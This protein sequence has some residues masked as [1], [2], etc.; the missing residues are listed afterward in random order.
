MIKFNKNPCLILDQRLIDVFAQKRFDE[1][2]DLNRI[3]Y[4]N[5]ESK[6]LD[7]LEITNKVSN[8]LITS[9]ENIEQ[10]LFIFGSNLKLENK[11]N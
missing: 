10:F 7:Y 6:Y 4:S 1:F 8:E 9:G 2:Q 11:S 3:S 5:A